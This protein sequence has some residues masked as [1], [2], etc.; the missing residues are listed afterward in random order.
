MV[1]R[2]IKKIVSAVI[3]LTMAASLC[4]I[5]VSASDLEAENSTTARIGVKTQNSTNDTWTRYHEGN[6]N[7]RKV[8][9]ATVNS[10]KSVGSTTHA[11]N[12]YDTAS[13]TLTYLDSGAKY[14]HSAFKFT[15]TKQFQIR[16]RDTSKGSNAN[17]QWMNFEISDGV[18]HVYKCASDGANFDA[19]TWTPGEE[20]RVDMVFN[21][22]TGVGYC[23]V[24]GVLASYGTN[25]QKR[26]SFEGYAIY[27]FETWSGGD[28]FEWKC[29]DRYVG[30]T[31]YQDTET[32][33]VTLEEVLAD[34][35]VTP[36]YSDSNLFFENDDIEDYVYAKN[37]ATLTYPEDDSVRIEGTYYGGYGYAQNFMN[38]FRTQNSGT[39]LAYLR[40]TEIG[41]SILC[42]T[43]AL[44]VAEG[45]RAEIRICANNSNQNSN[46]FTFTPD[47]ETGKIKVNGFSN[48]GVTLNKTWG[49]DPVNVGIVIDRVNHKAY[50]VADGMLLGDAFD[51]SRV[52]DFND[53]KVYLSGSSE[54][55]TTADATISNWSLKE[56][57]SAKDCIEL[58]AELEG[59]PVYFPENSNSLDTAE[60]DGLFGLA[61]TAKGTLGADE[62]SGNMYAAVYN[63][64]GG[65]I[66]VRIWEYVDSDTKNDEGLVFDL[67]EDVHKV[68]VFCLTSDFAGLARPMTYTIEQPAASEE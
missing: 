40:E 44:Q 45:N 23:F 68:K 49:E 59:M 19:G 64:D 7:D 34:K 20:N 50:S 30:Y 47:E 5:S 2:K 63:N 32:H 13:N 60:E 8:A 4:C 35:G 36:A 58:I 28:Y 33:K 9:K 14:V 16:V 1:L 46:R 67:T 53:L 57:Y 17:V 12:C 52:G 65:L 24:N 22:T 54:E 15:C 25:T 51:F 41:G 3:A 37:S 61:V 27:T 39:G 55:D 21:T 31:W 66:D 10:G 6:A 43:F 48:E 62:A 56:Y 29:I 11:V 38:F 26:G 18:G 42:M